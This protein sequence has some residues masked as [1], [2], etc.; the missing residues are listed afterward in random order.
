MIG[1]TPELITEFLGQSGLQT[2]P[3]KSGKPFIIVDYTSVG[4]Y[5]QSTLIIK[6]AIEGLL[7][8]G[9]PAEEVLKRIN[10]VSLNEDPDVKKFLPL[11]SSK[12]QIAYA[13]KK[14]AKSWQQEGLFE[15]VAV[16]P[17]DAAYNSE[18]HDKWGSIERNSISGRLQ[19]T[20]K[21]YFRVEAKRVV[22]ADM[23]SV[24][25]MASSKVFHNSVADLAD[26]N[27]VTIPNLKFDPKARS[28]GDLQYEG[29]IKDG[30]RELSK[31]SSNNEDLSEDRLKA[32]Y[33]LSGTGKEVIRV[34]TDKSYAEISARYLRTSLE[35]LI[36]LYDHQY[37]TTEDFFHIFNRVQS[38]KKVDKNFVEFV[39]ATYP[40]SLPLQVFLGREDIRASRYPSDN[41]NKLIQN[42]ALP[43]SCRFLFLSK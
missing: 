17:S 41:Y 31:V 23:A 38:L 33:F 35:T 12:S 7:K 25:N 22:Y 30:L 15:N 26:E 10:L 1:A 11:E 43:L 24:I 4:A 14:Q 34:L 6:S 39:K 13:L 36:N 18:W 29:H 20:P 40:N 32:H 27:G 3:D 9:V 42:G 2:K 28:L 5:S 37:I 19:T 21:S 8:N 16:I